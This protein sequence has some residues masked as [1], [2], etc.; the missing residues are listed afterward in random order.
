LRSGEAFD[1]IDDA[2]VRRLLAIGRDAVALASE[3]VR[4]RTP[5]KW[6]TKGDRDL[7]SDVDSAVEDLVRTYLMKQAPEVSFLGEEGGGNDPRDGLCWV[8]DPIDGTINYLHRVPLCAIS[9]CLIHNGDSLAAIIDLPFLR[10][11]YLTQRGFGAYTDNASIQVSQ[12]NTLGSALVSIDQYT[13][14]ENA[15]HNNDLRLRLTKLLASR[16]QRIRMIGSSAIDLVWTAEGLLDA[17]VIFGNK[18][19]DT[20]AGVLIAREAGAHVVDLDGTDH[21]IN[22]SATIA[23]TPA[24]RDD[25]MAIVTKA[26][27][28]S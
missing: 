27:L 25:L 22:S 20:S 11:R 24:L 1:A 13:F 23:V 10:T 8:L 3:L 4:S 28:P 26:A 5:R 21:S 17:C 14:G 15:A 2:G 16:V 7:A 18:P 9:L 6:T 19:W 12:T